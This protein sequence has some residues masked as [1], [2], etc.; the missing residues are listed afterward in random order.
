MAR[1]REAVYEHGVLRPVEPLVLPPRQHVRVTIE[2]T[3]GRLTWESPGPVNERREELRWL[4]TE[5]DSYA[6]EWVA[7]NGPGLV[8]QG[9]K[10]ASVSAA[11][12]P[13]PFFAR[14]PRHKD[15]SF[16]GW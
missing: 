6:G 13:D 14:V 2:D 5:S 15:A 1:Q 16:S 3:P 8:A 4:A 11:G 12:V 10:L 9:E 7:L